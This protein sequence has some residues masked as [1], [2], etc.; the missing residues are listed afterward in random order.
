MIK[1]ITVRM[2]EEE[3]RLAKVKALRDSQGEAQRAAH[4]ATAARAPSPLQ[5]QPPRP[6][7]L[8]GPDLRKPAGCNRRQLPHRT[9]R[10]RP[11][12]REQ[13]SRI[14]LHEAPRQTNLKT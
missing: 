2:D 14:G 6:P 10:L 12:I 8:H 5:W 11:R 3:K 1:F 4:C 7:S 9:N 13:L